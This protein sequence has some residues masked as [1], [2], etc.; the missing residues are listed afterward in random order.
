MIS[1]CRVGGL[2]SGKAGKAYFHLGD[3]IEKLNLLFSILDTTPL[4][5][6]QIL[7]THVERNHQLV[8]EGKKWI[9]RG[10]FCDFTASEE[11]ERA[12]LSY[13][14][15]NIT[16]NHITMSSDSYGSLP[17]FDERGN[18]IRYSYGKPDM[19]FSKIRKLAIDHRMG[20]EESIRL[21]TSN[22]ADFLEIQKGKLSVG[23]DADLLVLD[24]KHGIE[25]LFSRGEM[26]KNSTWTKKSMFA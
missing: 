20:W 13:K 5:I 23:F 24:A 22:V 16:W 8:E 10:G 1:D 6:K 26:L 21:S 18:V 2:I 25:Y 4:P 17:V 9:K 7:L 3:G 15:E 19:L 11:A 14:R 12:I